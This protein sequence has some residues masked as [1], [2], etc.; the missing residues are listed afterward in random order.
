[1]CFHLQEVDGAALGL[2]KRSDIVGPPL[3][4]MLGVKK[5][6]VA[7][8]LFREIR[9]LLLHGNADNYVD[10]YEERPFHRL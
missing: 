2:L 3:G 9:D 10:P 4:G 1:M 7:L 6:G 5:L 8:K